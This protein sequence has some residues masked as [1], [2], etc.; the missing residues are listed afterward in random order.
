MGKILDALAGKSDGAHSDPTVPGYFASPGDPEDQFG[1][2]NNPTQASP[3]PDKSTEAVAQQ[4]S[5]QI[6]YRGAEQHGVAYAGSNVRVD[7]G[8]NEGHQLTPPD[9]TD[10]EWETRQEIEPI[11]VRVVSTEAQTTTRRKISMF[12]FPVVSATTANH[13]AQINPRV[14]SY[15]P[16]RVS[17][18]IVVKANGG[19]TTRVWFSPDEGFVPN[20]GYPVDGTNVAATSESFDTKTTE[21]LYATLD[22]GAAFPAL[23]CVIEEYEIDMPSAEEQAKKRHGFHS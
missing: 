8:L 1:K 22:S 10:I 6:P 5:N 16:N 4:G 21:D 9:S 2:D 14:L 11:P 18:H 19:A 3:P 13:P 7:P 12:S 17:A 15:R 20:S 23:V